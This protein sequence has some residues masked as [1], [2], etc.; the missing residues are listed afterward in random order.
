MGLIKLLTD[1]SSFKFYANGDPYNKYRGK[2]YSYGPREVPYGND[3]PGGGT[4][5]D[6]LI[7]TPLPEVESSPTAKTTPDSLYRGQ[8]VLSQAVLDDTKRISKFLVTNEGLQFI[9]KQNAILIKDNIKRYGSNVLQWQFFNPAVIIG[10][11][12]LAA[13]GIR[14]KQEITFGLKPKVSRESKFGE[15][16]SSWKK[17]ND[18]TLGTDRITNSPMYIAQ[19][20]KTDPDSKESYFKDTVDLYFTKI[21][22]DGSGNNTYI[23]FR[24]YIKGLSDSYGADW[25]S[26]KYMGRGEDFFKYNGFDRDISFS[27]D[28][29]VL[30]AREQSMV[31]SKLN[32]MASCMAPDYTKGGFMRGNLFKMTIGDYIIDLPGV[33][34]GI[35]FDIDDSAGWDIDRSLYGDDA[36]TYTMPRLIRVGGFK[37]LPIHNF[38]PQTVNSDFISSGDG[39]LVNAPFISFGKT[40]QTETSTGGYDTSPQIQSQKNEE[41][42]RAV[43]AANQRAA[44]Q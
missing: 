11:T 16:D 32:Y 44:A 9:A 40:G 35:S 20:R 34:N 39:K 8:G 28:V 14:L 43:E 19:N 29:P 6:P 26:F 41:T 36:D 12:A 1:P 18:P 31:F 5:N 10:Q 37:F 27:F 7:T 15:F 38:I 22:N 2:G 3:R 17:K 33:L 13:T 21:N 4:S 30:S 25:K 24:S 42:K 23:H